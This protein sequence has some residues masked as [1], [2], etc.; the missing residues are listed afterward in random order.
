MPHR[1]Q[2]PI[3]C[4]Y[5]PPLFVLLL[6]WQCCRRWVTVCCNCQILEARLL[7]LLGFLASVAQTDPLPPETVYSAAA[8]LELDYSSLDPPENLALFQFWKGFLPS[9]LFCKSLL[10]LVLSGPHLCP[11]LPN[12]LLQRFAWAEGVNFYPLIHPI[13]CHDW[14]ACWN[15]FFSACRLSRSAWRISEPPFAAG[16]S[17]LETFLC[18]CCRVPWLST[19]PH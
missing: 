3:V 12:L 17:I 11:C 6:L 8:D 13:R 10:W 7:F 9:L 4:C 1:S 2:N 5:L 16:H 14:L 15:R 18:Q 19:H